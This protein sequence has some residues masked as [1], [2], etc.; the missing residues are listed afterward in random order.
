MSKERRETV[1]HS[2][3]QEDLTWILFSILADKGP[4]ALSM[5]VADGIDGKPAFFRFIG[6]VEATHQVISLEWESMLKDAEVI[7]ELRNFFKDKDT[8]VLTKTHHDHI[9]AMIEKSPLF[10]A[11]GSS[12]IVVTKEQALQDGQ[13]ISPLNHISRVAQGYVHVPLNENDRIVAQLLPWLHDVGKMAGVNF[14]HEGAVEDPAIREFLKYKYHKNGKHT[15]PSHAEMGTL[16]IKK[17]LQHTDSLSLKPEQEILLLSIIFHHHNFIYS[18]E[19]VHGPLETWLESE[20]SDMLIPTMPYY[21]PELVVRF[22]SL[23]AQFRYAD[24][25]ATQQH[26]VHWAGNYEWFLKLPTVLNHLL[27]SSKEVS[28]QIGILEAVVSSLPSEIVRV[29][30]KGDERHV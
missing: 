23:L 12:S 3:T 10:L 7:L 5:L 28:K 26:H 15:H 1:P 21:S 2:L 25:L 30:K 24:I 11:L 16:I 14:L 8:V 27:P 22:F 29:D 6:S 9:R 19:A 17:I 13:K 18:G 20:I 4:A